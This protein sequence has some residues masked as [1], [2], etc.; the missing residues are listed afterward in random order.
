MKV[1]PKSSL[2]LFLHRA[3]QLID[4]ENFS[5]K[6]SKIVKNALYP[7]KSICTVMHSRVLKNK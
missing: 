5:F 7:K 4:M 3:L 2:R 1:G 6:C